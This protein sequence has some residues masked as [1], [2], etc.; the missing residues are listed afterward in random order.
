[1]EDII[2]P[3][4]FL[5]YPRAI[6][7]KWNEKVSQCLHLLVCFHYVHPVFAVTDA[8]AVYQKVRMCV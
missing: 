6:G 4:D 3:K 5:M 7:I 1:M 2:D 8:I